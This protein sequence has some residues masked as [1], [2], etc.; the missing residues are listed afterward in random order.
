MELF[1][2]PIREKHGIL[3]ALLTLEPNGVHRVSFSFKNPEGSLLPKTP[4]NKTQDELP[5]SI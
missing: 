4:E 2:L 5:N 1:V 3:D